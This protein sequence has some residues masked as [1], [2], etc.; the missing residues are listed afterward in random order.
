VRSRGSG[1]CRP[2][3]RRNEPGREVRPNVLPIIEFKLSSMVLVEGTY[4]RSHSLGMLT[5]EDHRQIAERCIR[6]AK[7][8]TE[9]TVAEQLMTFAANHL[10]RALRLHQPA[11]VVRRQIKLV[12]EK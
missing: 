12:Q 5:S 9:P 4:D 6:L 3:A 8:C 11:T 10:E 7:T 1:A 2:Q